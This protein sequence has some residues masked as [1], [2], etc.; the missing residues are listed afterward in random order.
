MLRDFFSSLF[1]SSNP[2]ASDI[3]IATKDIKARLSED[4]KNELSSRFTM[5]EILSAVSNLNPTKAPGPD[6]FH[7]LF[8]QKA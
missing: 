7:A 8:F 4:M 3:Q 5:E 6:G 1:D 2:S